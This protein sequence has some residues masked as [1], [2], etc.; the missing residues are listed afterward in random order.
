M[1][2]LYE[3]DLPPATGRRSYQRGALGA[4]RARRWI[5][6]LPAHSPAVDDFEGERVDERQLEQLRDAIALLDD[7]QRAVLNTIAQE[8]HST[9]GS[10]STGVLPSRRR[11]LIA[12]ALVRWGATGGT[13][14]SCAALRSPRRGNEQCH[15]PI[16]LLGAIAYLLTI[17]HTTA[18]GDMVLWGSPTCH[19]SLTFDD[20]GTPCF[21]EATS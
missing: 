13:R 5:K 7:G 17:D 16:V 20:N 6:P 15:Q 11:W 3:L 9:G 8:A 4:P 19:F 1:C 12:R 14:T 10:I 18:L 21:A 2:T